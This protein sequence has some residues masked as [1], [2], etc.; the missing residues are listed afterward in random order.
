MSKKEKTWQIGTSG[1]LPPYDFQV[2]FK[3]S[4]KPVKMFGFSEQHIKDQCENKKPI[5]IKRT[6]EKKEKETKIER[7]GPKDA[8]VG[9]PAD[10]EPAFK[11]LRAWVDS[12]GGPPEDV[13]K[14]IREHW[15]DY[16]KVSKK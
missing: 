5:K 12:Q 15:I 6:K 13:R 2:W 8:P 4:K 11:I 7:L 9:R 3:G 14:A 10:Y 16:Q 1:T